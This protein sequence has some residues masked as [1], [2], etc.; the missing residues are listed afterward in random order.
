MLKN[1]Q[2]KVIFPIITLALVKEYNATEKKVFS[3]RGI[4][5]AYESTVNDLKKFLKHDVHIGG[6]YYDAYP[7]RNPPQYSV[8][9][10]FA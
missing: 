7:S 4:R 3:D 9:K 1:S 6:K 2:T 5:R 10:S 8:V